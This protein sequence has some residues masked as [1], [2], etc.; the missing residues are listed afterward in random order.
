MAKNKTQFVCQNC[1]SEA[2]KWEGKCREC[3][4]W[5]SLVEET[6][7]KA[8]KG[9]RGWSVGS[10][11]TNTPTV[12]KLSAHV[13]RKEN[14]RLNT[15]IGELNRVL[16]GGLVRGSYILLGGDPGIGKSTL[17]MQVAGK[18]AAE[19]NKV[20][21]VPNAL[22]YVASWLKWRAKAAFHIF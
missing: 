16:G 13:D 11:E 18:I 20:L 10:E 4:A 22:V 21:Y 14:L 6:V 3:G 17:L 12:L 15:G 7:I 2:A 19:K 9:A 1:G 5:N 8:P